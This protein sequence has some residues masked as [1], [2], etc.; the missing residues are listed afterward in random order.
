MA[1]DGGIFGPECVRKSG[2]GL[3]VRTNIMRGVGV[4]DAQA[5]GGFCGENGFDKMKELVKVSFVLLLLGGK[6]GV[7]DKI[8]QFVVLIE[9]LNELLKMRFGMCV[10]AVSGW[11]LGKIGTGDD[12]SHGLSGQLG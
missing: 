9:L 6:I 10:D 5:M 12:L 1:M 4:Q 2:K 11:C 7:E 8:G 3:I